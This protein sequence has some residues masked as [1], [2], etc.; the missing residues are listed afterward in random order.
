[1]PWSAQS[2]ADEVSTGKLLSDGALEIV[3]LFRRQASKL[4]YQTLDR[5][6]QSSDVEIT[7][8]SS[9]GRVPT[10]LIVNHGNFLVF[11]PDGSTLTGSKQNRVVNTSVLLPAKSTTEIPV[12]CV[13]QGRWRSVAP[14]SAP[15]GFGDKD[16]RRLMCKGTTESLK[17]SG[18]V[19]VDQSAVWDHVSETMHSTRT[20]SASCDYE[21]ALAQVEQMATPARAPI[22]LPKDACGVAL[23][24][25]GGIEAVDLFD[26][27]STLA[28]VWPRLERGYRMTSYRS[29]AAPRGKGRAEDLLTAAAKGDVETFASIGVGQNLRFTAKEAVAA[30]LVYEET[31]VH[32]SVFAETV[33]ESS[34]RTQRDRKVPPSSRETPVSPPKQKTS[35][36]KRLRGRE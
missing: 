6:V 36:W 22:E 14:R 33:A 19:Q 13:E 23:V 15:T 2:L 5:A 18:R 17:S 4:E 10:L 30:A 29:A 11:I 21:A 9:T 31:P 12:S 32:V 20:Q 3:P 28:E 8:V 16:M 1:M 35:W 7:E 34:P 26:K 24:V 27:P 25:N